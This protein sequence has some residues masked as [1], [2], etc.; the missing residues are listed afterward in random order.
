M[1]IVFVI[2]AVIVVVFSRASLTAWKTLLNIKSVVSMIIIFGAK[3]QYWRTRTRS[4]GNYQVSAR[5]CR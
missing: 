3:A 2:V 1:I 4:D 5:M